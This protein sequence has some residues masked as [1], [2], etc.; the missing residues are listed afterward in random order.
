MKRLIALLAMVFLL[1]GMQYVQAQ[2]QLA[3]DSMAL[4]DVEDTTAFVADSAMA[5]LQADLSDEDGEMME[6]DG[7]LHKQLKRKFIEGSASF[8]SL[9]ALA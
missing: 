5:V 3:E 8:M 4:E 9:V 2:D 1:A 6:E 7:G